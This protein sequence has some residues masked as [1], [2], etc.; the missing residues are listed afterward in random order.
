MPEWLWSI[1]V[2]VIVV[3]LL[4]SVRQADRDRLKELEDWRKAKE[5]F[6]YKFRHNEYA[7]KIAGINEKLLP[8]IADVEGLAERMKR[9][10]RALNGK[11][12]E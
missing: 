4:V 3:G 5:D 6:D 1:V 2:G 9:A 8:L 11:L 12:H 10:E 7:P